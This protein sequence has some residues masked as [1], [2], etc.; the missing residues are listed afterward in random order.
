MF[1]PVYSGG[2]SRGFWKTINSMKNTEAYSLG[3]VLQ[4]VEERILFIL[5]NIEK[6]EEAAHG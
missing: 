1:V 3:V 6:K 4:T 2:E 5:N